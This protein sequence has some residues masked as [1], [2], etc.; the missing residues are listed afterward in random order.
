MV[1]KPWFKGLSSAKRSSRP[2]LFEEIW[3]SVE[4]EADDEPPKRRGVSVLLCHL[5]QKATQPQRPSMETLA[6]ERSFSEIVYMLTDNRVDTAE[7]LYDPATG[8]YGE[9]PLH[10]LLKYQP[11]L[12]VVRLLIQKL[13]ELN[14]NSV[15]EAV[16]DPKG[17]TPLHIACAYACSI[18]VIARLMNGATAKFRNPAAVPDAA[19]MVPLHWACKAV[20]SQDNVEN[21][22]H[23]IGFLVEAYP[24]GVFIANGRGMN[25][26]DLATQHLADPA[27][28]KILHHAIRRQ[29][30]EQHPLDELL[31]QSWVPY[32]IRV[33]PLEEG[34]DNIS[35]I[36]W[37]GEFALSE[38]SRSGSVA[39]SSQRCIRSVILDQVS[40]QGGS[41]VETLE[42]ICGAAAQE[43]SQSSTEDDE[44]LM[45]SR[46]WDKDHFGLLG[47]PTPDKKEYYKK[48]TSARGDWVADMSFN[49]IFFGK[50][51]A[52]RKLHEETPHALSSKQRSRTSLSTVSKTNASWRHSAFNWDSSEHTEQTESET[53]K[54]LTQF[55]LDSSDRGVGIIEQ[56]RG[57]PEYFL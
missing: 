10:I 12:H 4:V 21:M 49:S 39:A 40:E 38:H 24:E 1:R 33:L 34:G 27:I 29:Q 57:E 54:S 37:G 30:H 5:Q 25:P 23:V 3:N 7:W 51:N 26:A 43:D 17:R 56:E 31:D 50:L 42:S 55:C 6:K 46:G 2:S 18:A 48:L 15:P 35:S 20:V 19:H 9:S 28:I 16:R 8:T 14:R 32:E 44:M 41:C 52:T 53:N 47:E 45:H 13:S 11:P 22:V 36:G